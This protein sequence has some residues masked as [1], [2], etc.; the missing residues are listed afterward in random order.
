RRPGMVAVPLVVAA[1][2]NNEPATDD[3]AA[4]ATTSTLSS[5]ATESAGETATTTSS[6]VGSGSAGTTQ[7]ASTSAGSTTAASTMSSSGDGTGGPPDLGPTSGCG[8]RSIVELAAPEAIYRMSEI[9]FSFAQLTPF[10][11]S[12]YLPAGF[13]VVA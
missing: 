2:F 12:V 13:F 7:D 5:T 11:R 8:G 9:P 3:G 1:C 10:T 6:T 4:T